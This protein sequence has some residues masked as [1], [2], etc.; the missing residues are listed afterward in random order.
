[1]ESAIKS[2]SFDTK[3]SSFAC[4]EHRKHNTLQW[5]TLIINTFR[6]PVFTKEKLAFHTINTFYS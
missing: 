2:A 4:W 5:H 1:M 6:G 3:I